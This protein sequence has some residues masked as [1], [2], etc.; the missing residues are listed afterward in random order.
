[1]ALLPQ[2]HSDF[3]GILKPNTPKASSSIEAHIETM[4][5]QR[6]SQNK[7]MSSGASGAFGS[8]SEKVTERP[9]PRKGS[10]TS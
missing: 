9:R 2:N 7:G 4:T 8:T 6:V 1:M 5:S 10:V 3:A